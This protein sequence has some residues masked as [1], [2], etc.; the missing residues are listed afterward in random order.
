MN[1]I[2]LFGRLTA[3]PSCEV[4][5][6]GKEF[7]RFSVA[8]RRKYGKDEN[9]DA[10]TDFINCTAWRQTALFICKYFQKGRSILIN[11]ELQSSKFRDKNGNNRTEWG[12]EVSSVD[13]GGD[14]PQT[15]AH[16]QAYTDVVSGG[17]EQNAETQAL[18][19]TQFAELAENE[20]LPF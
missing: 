14:S 1:N 7:C 6:G 16:A 5:P 12:V 11:G 17:M 20:D 9:G 13:F 10:I 3:N 2:T 4:T 15:Q 19:E 8:V 18:R